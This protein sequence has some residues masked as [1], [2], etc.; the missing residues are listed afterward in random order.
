MMLFKIKKF[1][2]QS[3]IDQKNY[4]QLNGH[5]SYAKY[6]FKEKIGTKEKKFN[7]AGVYGVFLDDQLIY[8]GKFQGQ[9]DDWNSGNVVKTRWVKHIGTF[10]MLDKKVSFNPTIYSKIFKNIK[11]SLNTNKNLKIL[12]SGFLAANK[13]I[14]TRQMDCVSSFERFSIAEKIWK[15]NPDLE[16]IL[17]RFSFIYSKLEGKCDTQ[18][19]INLVSCI[20]EQMIDLLQ[21]IANNIKKRT[22]K[23]TYSSEYTENLFFKIF[24][25]E[26]SLFSATDDLDIALN[27]KK[28]NLSNSD[29]FLDIIENSNHLTKQFVNKLISFIDHRSDSSIEYIKYKTNKVELRIRKHIDSKLGFRNVVTFE[30]QPNKKRLLMRSLLSKNELENNFLQLDKIMSDGLTNISYIYQKNLVNN[31]GSVLTII[32]NA[33]L[34]QY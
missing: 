26:I 11:Q 23:L 27:K 2:A 17:S 32:H 1:K 7:G 28:E 12:H 13:N 33:I 21:P 10:T 22:K 5:L 20:E 29:L 8:I 16:N 15:N 3:I 34:K 30:W 25:K 18:K 6:K 4:G 24:T 31:F 9:K 14:L 19:I